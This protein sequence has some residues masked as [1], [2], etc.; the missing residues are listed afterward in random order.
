MLNLKQL[1]LIVT[2]LILKFSGFSQYYNTTE[3]YYNANKNIGV[4]GGAYFFNVENKNNVSYWSQP[5]GIQNLITETNYI[6]SDPYNGELL[7]YTL[8]YAQG[9]LYS[10]NHTTQF[11]N[12]NHQ[13]IEGGTFEYKR[14]LVEMMHIALITPSFHNDYLFHVF[15]YENQEDATYS[16]N[17]MHGILDMKANNGNGKFISKGTVLVPSATKQFQRGAIPGNNCNMWVLFLSTQQNKIYTFQIKGNEIDT[18]PII[19]EVVLKAEFD[20]SENPVFKIAPDRQTL[21]M[22]S[23]LINRDLTSDVF[24]Q[25]LNFLKFNLDEGTVSNQLKVPTDIRSSF[26]PFANYEFIDHTK[27]LASFNSFTNFT[28]KSYIIDL[29]EY[30]RQYILDNLVDVSHINPTKR[31]VEFKKYKDYQYTLF[32]KFSRMN[33]N[34]MQLETHLGQLGYIGINDLNNG[35][36][37]EKM[38]FDEK[39]QLNDLMNEPV[40][41]SN[42][43][44]SAEMVYPLE[45]LSN[46]TNKVIVENHCFQNELAIPLSAQRQSE[47]YEWDDGSTNETRIITQPGTYWVKYPYKCIFLTDSFYIKDIFEYLPVKD[48]DTQICMQQ[49]PL[50]FQYPDVVDSVLYNGNIV[51]NN[52]FMANGDATYNIELFKNGC[53]TPA[54]IQVS[55]ESCPCDIFA[56]NAFTPNGDGLNDLFKPI[57]LNGCVPIDYEFHIFN[58]FGNRIFIAHQPYHEGWDG[59]LNGKQCINDTYIFELRFKDAYTGKDFYYKGDVTLI[60]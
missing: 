55:S 7:F 12:K 35:V 56:P 42:N 23:T 31:F 45:Y 24:Y 22:S 28:S 36:Q 50:R 51:E 19:S 39:T 44:F 53:V 57:T 37:I 48:L 15:Y 9:S 5:L 29:T 59:T 33:P 32:P 54:K 43:F 1:I 47:S 49:Y 8:T 11:F 20:D 3:K 41:L 25:E 52:Y 10:E 60:R 13:P 46:Y 27:I 16:I 38:N 18:T 17:L 6:A 34:T 58:R 21:F 26:I 40:R 4:Y 2:I 30:N 14:T